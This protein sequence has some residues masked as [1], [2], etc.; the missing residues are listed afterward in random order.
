MDSDLTFRNAERKDNA[1]YKGT[2]G[3]TECE[4]YSELDHKNVVYYNCKRMVG[5]FLYKIH[6]SV[7]IHIK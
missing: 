3:L 4:K 1:I 6:K 7:H 5:Q 2:C